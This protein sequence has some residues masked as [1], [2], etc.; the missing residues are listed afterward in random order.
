MLSEVETSRISDSGATKAM[1]GDSSTPLRCAQNDKNKLVKRSS[2]VA[3][4]P[5]G[6]CCSRMGLTVA[7]ASK[8]LSDKRAGTRKCE[9]AGLK[10]SVPQRPCMNHVRPDF[11]SHANI[12]CAS[13]SRKTSR[14]IK[15]RLG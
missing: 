12:G 15:Q 5:S 13:N 1:N 9:A 11:Q 10:M 3:A 14:I 6:A 2:G 4:I 7:V 8:I